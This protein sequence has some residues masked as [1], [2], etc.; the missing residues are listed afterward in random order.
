MELFHNHFP[1]I[2]KRE[3]RSVAILDRKD[4]A[5]GSYAFIDLYCSERDCDCRNVMINV[6]E[7][8]RGHLATINH[9][10]DPDGFKDVGMPRTFLDPLNVQAKEAPA[11]LKLFKELLQDKDYA[12]RLERHYRMVKEKVDRRLKAPS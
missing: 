10:L 4:M 8:S 1:E 7:R 2:A 5:P 9:A 12:Q 11:L 6:V 3:T